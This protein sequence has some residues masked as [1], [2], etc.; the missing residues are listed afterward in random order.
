VHAKMPRACRAN[1]ATRTGSPKRVGRATRRLAAAIAARQSGAAGGARAPEAAERAP[2]ADARQARGEPQA[3]GEAARQAA[4]HGGIHLRV[5]AVWPRAHL[6]G[7]GQRWGWVAAGLRRSAV[8]AKVTLFMRAL[9]ADSPRVSAGRSALATVRISS[10]RGAEHGLSLPFPDAAVASAKH[11]AR[12]APHSMRLLMATSHPPRNPGIGGP[13]WAAH[14]APWSAAG[15]PGV[16][17]LRQL[18]NTC[19]AQRASS[20]THSREA[21]GAAHRARRARRRAQPLHVAGDRHRQRR[22]APLRGAE[23]QREAHHRRDAC[24]PTARPGSASSQSVRPQV[25]RSG[26]APSGMM[27]K[28][29][30]WHGHRRQRGGSYGSGPGY[31]CHSRRSA[32]CS[33]L[34][35]C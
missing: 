23:R 3:D 28:R 19:C 6:R 34:R 15:L 5:Q 20:S 11:A 25:A 26:D 35:L 2:Q 13:A 29:T 30:K 16:C 9:L 8:R 14:A 17:E 33:H 24:G 32:T 10:S 21:S 31:N 18:A 1:W 7:P 27:Y 12:V 22:L 4:L